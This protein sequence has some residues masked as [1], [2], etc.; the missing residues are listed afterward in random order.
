MVSLL[1]GLKQ[2]A[3]S[4]NKNSQKS[5]KTLDYLE[6]SQRVRIPSNPKH[7]SEWK[8]R[9]GSSNCYR[10]LQIILLEFQAI[11]F[12]K[13]FSAFKTYHMGRL[14]GIVHKFFDRTI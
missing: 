14:F 1:G 13:A 8:V 12:F 11:I 5:T 3:N 2:A 9:T 10:L 6:T 7:L 4:V